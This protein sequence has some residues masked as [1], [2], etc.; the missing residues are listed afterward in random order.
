MKTSQT[1]ATIAAAMCMLVAPTIGFQQQPLRPLSSI[2]LASSSSAPNQFSRFGKTRQQK[3][4]LVWWT[5][6][7]HQRNSP[8][9]ADVA[10]SADGGKKGLFD[11]VCFR[12]ASTLLLNCSARWYFF[13]CLLGKQIQIHST[14]FVSPIHPC[15]IGIKQTI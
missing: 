2:Q 6:N 9:M 15:I 1:F 14:I 5:S 8:L 4:K 7:Q 11:K 3:D 13:F 12:L 10:A